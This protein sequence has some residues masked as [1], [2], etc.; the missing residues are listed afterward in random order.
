[1]R[2][3]VSLNTNIIG[4]SREYDLPIQ[5]DPGF[6]KGSIV[7]GSDGIMQYSDGLEWR[8][9]ETQ[10][11][12]EVWVGEVDLNDPASV[13]PY[14]RRLQFARGDQG[15]NNTFTGNVAEVFFNTDKN[16][17]VVH[18]G[19][20]EGGFELINSSAQQTLSNKT[21]SLVD[22]TIV[23][24]DGSGLEVVSGQLN[25]DNTVVRTTGNQTIGGVKTFTSQ[26]NINSQ[27]GINSSQSEFNIVST[28]V[29]N[30][31]LGNAATNISM[32]AFSG[33]TTINHDLNVLGSLVVTG[34]LI[35][36][37]EEAILL[38]D[39]ILVLLDTETPTDILA[40]GGGIELNGDTTKTFKWFN[41]T[42]SWT[43]SENLDVAVGKTYKIGG[44]DV[45]SAT[46]LGQS[47]VNSSLESVGVVESG[48]WEADTI[49]V[50]YGGT[51]QT[52]YLNGELLIGNTTG[53]TLSKGTLTAGTGIG[54][55]NGAG[56]ITI[57]NTD[58][59]SS[60]N[61][62]KNV[63]DSDGNVEFVASTNNDTIRFATAGALDIAFDD[64]TKTITIST[65]LTDLST[66]PGIIIDAGEIQIDVSEIVTI[67]GTQTIIGEKT[68]F[69]PIVGSVTGNA[70][71]ASRLQIARN[72][73]G[74]A[75]DGTQDI[76]IPSALSNA[77]TFGDGLTGGSFDGTF[78][79]TVENTD[80]GTAQNIFKNI[81]N[82][83]D[84]IQFSASSNND[85]IKIIGEGAT[86]IT[87]DATENAI[88]ISSTDTFEPFIAGDGLTQ[89]GNTTSVDPNVVVLRT[90]NQT[91]D[92]VK[93]F[94]DPI[95]GELDGN[96]ATVT[97][98]MY[99]VGD[100]SVDGNK[101]FVLPI[102]GN[103]NGNAATVTNGVYTV[104]NQ[105]I[106][107]IKTFSSPIVADI[108]GASD[109]ANRLT[110]PRSINGTPFDGSESID[111][112]RWGPTSNFTIGATTKSVDGTANYNWTITEVIPITTSI[113][114]GS[115]GVGVAAPGANGVTV[116]GDISSNG[117]ITAAA[118]GDINTTGNIVV[119][120]NGR[121][122]SLGVG[123][124]AS[125][126]SGE[127]RS[128]GDIVAHFSD[129][130][131]KTRVGDIENA[132]EKVE[133][134]SA[135]YYEANETAQDL[136]Y[137]SERNVGLSAQEVEKVI[138]EAVKPAPIDDQYLT[139]QYE[140]LVPLLVAAIKELK[141]EINELK[142]K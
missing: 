94:N 103:L 117:T 129:D 114:L 99:I 80:R 54:V 126:V 27:L 45:L 107:G 34:D 33:Q 136:G 17:L 109:T 138:P 88:I 4:P 96:A 29:T 8:Q 131:L 36:T 37:T 135:F 134:L 2:R 26:V 16:T 139:V 97:N 67:N 53:N 31:N 98:G 48:T 89:V 7:L 102:I 46:T 51:G 38:E 118:F 84:N 43:S 124:D 119:G 57:A 30:I 41:S 35:T 91:I 61:I 63:A 19:S 3:Q 141:K 59:G 66:G 21:L 122:D 128:T 125:G 86:N 64:N 18:D 12:D 58:R 70:G 20:T 108:T 137:S 32:G 133:T 56:S 44:S 140:K 101:T 15:F 110:T 79:L 76:N 127:I 104:G 28:G 40:N 72:I 100:Q 92:G 74:V 60:Q 42:G 112:L 65:D 77:V 93:T 106:G 50:L 22:N 49:G 62:F 130:R 9:L 24:I 23:G 1:M 69:L 10:L 87:F 120:G 105:V 95:V 25:V 55:T 142:S 90:T 71:S 85:N 39:K 132:L 111:T 47:V 113:Q 13:S 83:N 14:V 81:L 5:L 123:T 11:E 68:F 75:F 78:P 52:S 121:V 73:N 82:E 6:Y 115:I 116:Q